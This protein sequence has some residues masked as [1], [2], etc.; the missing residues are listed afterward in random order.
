MNS[1]NV[2]AVVVTCN[3]KELL[4]ECLMALARQAVDILIIDNAS[5]DGTNQCVKNF[6]QAYKKT[7]QSN[8]VMYKRLKKNT[9]GAGGFFNGIKLAVRMNYDYVW[10]MDDDTIVTDNTLSELMVAKEKLNGEFGYLSSD[11]LWI[12]GS[13]CKMNVQHLEGDRFKNSY[14]LLNEG[15]LPIKSASFVS[16]FI[17]C[18]AVKECGLPYKEYFIWG[19]DKEYTLRISR[20]YAC[21]RVKKS[22]VTHKMK[23]NNGS[24]IIRDDISR[25]ERYFYAYRNDFRTACIMG[26]G[27][28]YNYCVVFFRTIIRI[29]KSDSPAKFLRIKTMFKGLCEGLQFAPN[30]EYVSELPQTLK[31][32]GFC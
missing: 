4:S 32:C 28:V 30:I 10:I 6:I 16:L 27:D 14:Q 26:A 22:I 17:N 31:V 19:D 29:L 9:G 7:P 24:D 23:S 18:K 3:R 8:K 15:I 2:L 21:Y 12:D 20:K 1:E 25:I 13:Y 5:T 11:A